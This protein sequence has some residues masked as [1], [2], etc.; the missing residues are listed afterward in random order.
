MP[1]KVKRKEL[2]KEP[3]YIPVRNVEE[4]F[5]KVK[6]IRFASIASY[7]VNNLIVLLCTI[8]YFISL[9]NPV[10]MINLFALHP[11]LTTL[12]LMPWQLVTSI[13]LH[14]GFWHLFVNMFVLFFFGAELERRVGSKKYL[15]IFLVSGLV[16]NLAYIVYAYVTGS[17]YPALGASAAIFGVMACL[18]VI[19]PNMKIIIFPFPIPINIRVALVLFAIFDFWMMIANS[20]GILSTNIAN[21]AHLAGLFAGLYYGKILKNS[22]RH[23]YYAYY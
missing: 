1:V 11:L 7:G 8:I 5:N 20:V 19:A 10:L 13:F 14:V 3:V 9:L 18:A 23:N 4:K 16:G 6:K 21:V 15:E 22:W 12:A 17:F 2:R